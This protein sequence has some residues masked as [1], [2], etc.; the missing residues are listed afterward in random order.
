MG[1]EDLEYADDLGILPHTQRQMQVR[2]ASAASTPEAT[3]LNI[4]QSKSKILMYN[5]E[6]TDR[7]TLDGEALLDLESFTYTSITIDKREGSDTDINART[8][9]SRTA[10]LHLKSIWDS[11]QY[12]LWLDTIKNNLLCER[13]NQQYLSVNI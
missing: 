11:K 12:I 4:H 3:G 10:S 5:M 2:T 1:P 13:T 8:G 7:R 9:K 6:D